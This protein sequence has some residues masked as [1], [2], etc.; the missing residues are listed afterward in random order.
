MQCSSWAI[1][2]DLAAEGHRIEAGR[3][4]FFTCAIVNKLHIITTTTTCL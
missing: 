1:G 2:L 3:F 4:K